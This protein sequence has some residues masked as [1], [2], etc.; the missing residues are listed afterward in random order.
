MR[1]FLQ[2]FTALRP[3]PIVG[4][5]IALIVMAGMPGPVGGSES[6]PVVGQVVQ[7]I[8][9]RSDVAN[10]DLE[11]L[12]PLLLIEVGHPLSQEDLARSLRNLQASGLVSEVEVFVDPMPDGVEVTFVTWGRIQV[13]EIAFT[14]ELKVKERDLR[15]V[16]V[17]N[18]AEPLVTSRI[19]RGVYDL[20]NYYQKLGYLK[21]S[22]RSRPRIDL[23][24]K[25]ASVTYDVDPGPRFFVQN[26]AF[27]GPIS[28]FTAPDL[29]DRLRM[30]PG[31]PFRER[32]A[33]ADMERLE[34]WLFDQDH[35]RASVGP[36][37]SSIDWDTAEVAVT[38]QVDVGP[39]FLFEIHGAD[40]RRLR[41]K[42]LLPFLGTQRY[43]EAILLQSIDKIEDYF[44]R[45]GHYDVQID[46]RE[47]RTDE[48]IHLVMTIDPGPTY[49]LVDISFV[50]NQ[51]VPTYQLMSLISTESKR[52]FA[53]ASGR[54]SETTLEDDIENILSYY[55]IQGYWDA[56]VGPPEVTE[57]DG[58]LSI[59]VPVDEGLER[60]LVN[61]I[62]DGL[63]AVDESDLRGRLPLRPGGPFHPVLLEETVSAIRAFY[64]AQG[65]ESVQLSS[66][67]DWNKEETLVDVT[68]RILEG[69]RSVVDRVVVRG[70]QR[71][72]SKSIRDA[73]NLGTGAYIS[74][75]RLLEA[76]NNLYKL[77]AFSSVTVKRAPGTPFKGER[78]ILVEVEEG[79]R[80][81][82]TYGFG[83]DTEDGFT[84][85][86]GYTRS[87]MFGRGVSGRV[88]LRAGRDSLARL[89]L[90]QPFLGS[91][92]ITTTGSLFYIEETRDA[93]ESLR[94]GGQL[95]A[96]RLGN[97]SRTGILFDYRLV[98]QLDL[99]TGQNATDPDDPKDRDLE[100]IEIASL[101]PAW[102]LDH[103]DSPVNPMAGWSTNLQVQYAFPLFQAD[104]EFLKS[105]LQ[106]THFFDFG[107]LGSV[108][109]SLRL[110]G[111]EPLDKAEN[112]LPDPLDTIEVQE[113][114]YIAISERYFA[115]GSTTHRAY[116]RDKLGIC[117]ETLVPYFQDG[118]PDLPVEELCLIAPDYRAIGGNG[119]LLLN[120]DYRFPIAGPFMGN[121]FVDAGNVWGSWRRINLS[122]IKTGVGL[123]V[124]Y[125]SPVGPI[126]LEAGWKLDPLPGEDPYV[127][128]FS[129]GNAF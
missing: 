44:Q 112:R 28:P 1:R 92:R 42:G 127:I 39:R 11:R 64:R 59:A 8:N 51:A 65:F 63:E 12:R 76:Q 107:W 32:Q 104:E 20:E 119:Q 26:I 121:V 52:L 60:R 54:L 48:L 14:G 120:L 2:G 82:F 117:G 18:E 101:T 122:E 91:R 129:V 56:E 124:R 6:T 128:F 74:T 50:G 57:L 27:E 49:E 88:D 62:L 34:L 105:F 99:V 85:L 16:L 106:Y 7:R 46:W 126:R 125:L 113:S 15:A 36:F 87:N 25:T 98:D 123:G 69:P 80:H 100:E 102:Q 31:K 81:T 118:A 83:L 4:L 114:A 41:K 84:G 10:L 95:E 103:R 33:R 58:Q 35:R 66:S 3:P 90:Y 37:V 30:S 77:G 24:N 108:G 9:L 19:V 94:R 75:G 29:L 53:A 5:M 78:D 61:L 93:F 116:N 68:F 70:N 71:T 89:L 17:Q 23:E 22:V 72:R 55:R 38:Y 115:G 110:G 97:N 47:N 73:L 109:G 67:V 45:Q 13:E 43:D 86:F 40:E 96:Q 21:A 111:I 79:S